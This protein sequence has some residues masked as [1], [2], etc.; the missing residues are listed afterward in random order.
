VTY[1]SIDDLVSYARVEPLNYAD[2]RGIELTLTKNRG[3]WLRGFINYTYLVRKGGDFG[4]GQI[5]ENRRAQ[6]EYANSPA[7]LSSFKPIPEPFVRFNVELLLPPSLGPEVG[8][9][10]PFGDWRINFLGEWRKGAP[11]TWDGGFFN[12]NSPGQDLRISYNVNWKDYRMLDLRLS[13]NVGTAIGRAQLFVDITNVL[14]LKQLYYRNGNIFAGTDDERDY[15]RSLH[16]PDD[17]FIEE[18]NPG[19][20]WVPGDDKPGDFRKPGVAFDPI[21]VDENVQDGVPSLVEDALYYDLATSSYVTNSGGTWSPAD[22][23]RVRQVLD[24]KAYIDMPNNLRQF[25]N[26]RNVFFGVR[27]SF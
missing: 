11:S 2:N 17:I 12:I 6:A 7:A 9:F 8:G 4:F 25:L 22:E 3:Q 15:M 19:Y 5:D 16:L 14:N 26:P 21:F 1:I 18:F 23:S 13:K 27:L 20:A 10:R 24:D